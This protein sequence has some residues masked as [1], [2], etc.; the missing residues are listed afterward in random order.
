MKYRGTRKGINIVTARSF[1]TTAIAF[2]LATLLLTAAGA[3]RAQ[4]SESQAASYKI[5]VVDFRFIMKEYEKRK[6]EYNK[7]QE[8]VEKLQS[9]ID[10]L[11]DKIKAL[12]EE[13]DANV[14]TWSS[15]KREE[16]ESEIEVLQDDYRSELAKRQRIIDRKERDVVEALIKEVREVVA[17]IGEQENFHL[18]LEANSPNPPRGGVIYYSG[19]IDITSRVLQHLNERAS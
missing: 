9:D 7:L 18:I 4:E 6:D 2:M 13:Y 3:P 10:N 16:V 15:E 1:R 5:G 12:R 17:E 14:A 19:T 11:F 8:E